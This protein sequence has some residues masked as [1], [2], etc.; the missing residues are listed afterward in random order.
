MK[1]GKAI[2][3]RCGASLR[4]GCF[5]TI[6]SATTAAIAAAAPPVD[7]GKV[8]GAL[9]VLFGKGTQYPEKQARDQRPAEEDLTSQPPAPKAPLVAPPAADALQASKK[10]VR[11]AYDTEIKAAI[12]AEGIS[13]LVAELTAFAD[14]KAVSATDRYALLDVALEVATT[15][16]D[17]REVQALLATR[18]E[19]FT[20]QDGL[21]PMLQFLELR[22][23]DGR[24]DAAALIETALELSRAAMSDDRPDI[25]VKAVEAAAGMVARLSANDADRLRPRVRSQESETAGVTSVFAAAEQAAKVLQDRPADAKSNSQLGFRAAIVGDWAAAIGHWQKG[26]NA[27]LAAAA[28]AEAGLP[29]HPAA[30]D[31]H[32]VAGKWWDASEPV[33]PQQD[34]LTGDQ[35]IMIP[36]VVQSAIRRH[37][38]TLYDR[39]LHAEPGLTDALDV[40]L[41]KTRVEQVRGRQSAA[42]MEVA[43]PAL[44]VGSQQFDEPAFRAAEEKRADLFDDLGRACANRDRYNVTRLQRALTTVRDEWSRA[45]HLYNRDQALPRRQE[46]VKEVLRRQPDYADAHLCDCYLKMLDGKPGPAKE[47][48]ARAVNL[49]DKEP[50][51][52]LFCGQQLLDAGAAALMLGDRPLADKLKNFFRRGE[53]AGHPG[54]R[55]YEAMIYVDKKMFSEA[56]EEL[57]KVMANTTGLDRPVIAAEYAWLRAASPTERL[58]NKNAA[59]AAVKETLA[60]SSGPQ[61][62]AWRAHAAL[63][64]SEDRWDAAIAAVD[65]ASQQAPMLFADELERQRRSYEDRAE[66]W[67]ERKR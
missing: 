52:Q 55:L 57:E 29:A 13:K 24:G 28:A 8:P 5:A 47:S 15:G 65:R 46:L 58:R 17:P 34:K 40:R 2:G 19:R 61:W 35:P 32:A 27:M 10:K 62:K 14:G 9:D 54:V 63:L 26:R 39:A 59:A 20:G 53:F 16:T 60:S 12:N 37:A 36:P 22:K 25:A 43:E 45:L 48:L 41:A 23:A 44:V 38:S 4:A 67:I 64:A 6:V 42:R 66:Y 21:R 50:A 33:V 56:V 30:A 51:R 18:A 3:E 7:D 49:L 11:D 31:L 1:S